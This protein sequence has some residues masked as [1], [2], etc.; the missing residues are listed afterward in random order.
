ML[1]FFYI[2]VAHDA[3]YLYQLKVLSLTFKQQK[4]C[5]LCLKAGLKVCT[6]ALLLTFHSFT[7][8]M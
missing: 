5:N 1:I 2:K 4:G 7:E 8:E 3:P 6:A